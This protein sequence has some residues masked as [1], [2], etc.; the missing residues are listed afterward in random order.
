MKPRLTPLEIPFSSP[1]SYKRFIVLFIISPQI[2]LNHPFKLPS[3]TRFPW[4]NSPSGSPR[5][6]AELVA[7]GCGEGDG[8]EQLAG[9]VALA[10]TEGGDESCNMLE[11]GKTR[12]QN[13]EMQIQDDFI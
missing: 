12:R 1:F 5:R 7:G 9:P 6:P 11:L 10:L 13:D 4:G 2:S 3:P 8:L